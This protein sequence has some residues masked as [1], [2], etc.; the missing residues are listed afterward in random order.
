MTALDFCH[1]LF[2]CAIAPRKL[3]G[4]RFYKRFFAASVRPH[5][6][7]R[8]RKPIFFYTSGEKG[9][10]VFIPVYTIESIIQST[11]SPFTE[12]NRLL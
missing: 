11:N 7:V 8:M 10:Y 2:P 4:N 6:H 3:C 9:F 12:N 1:K 5:K